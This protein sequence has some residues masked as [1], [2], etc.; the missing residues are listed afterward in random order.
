MAAHSR[1]IISDRKDTAAVS[2]HLLV[3]LVPAVI[4][5]QYM[6]GRKSPAFYPGEG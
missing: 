6:P 2:R 3:D 4:D 1:G 5:H